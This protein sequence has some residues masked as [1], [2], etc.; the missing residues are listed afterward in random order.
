MPGNPGTK[1]DTATAPRGGTMVRPGADLAS[2]PDTAEM[3]QRYARIL[4]GPR[5]IAVDGLIVLTGLFTAISPWV[6]HFQDTNP[7]LTAVNLIVGLALTGLGLG[8]ALRPERMF[9]LGWVA[10]AIG[11]WLIISP[12]VA[13]VGNSAPSAQIWTNVCTGA[14]AFVLGLIALGLSGRR[15]KNGAS[16][17]ASGRRMRARARARAR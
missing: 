15:G 6:V 3:D 14:V 4:Q 1:P 8:M 2:H 5:A 12:W 7:S 9:K 16:G 10:S 13:S 17:G 11:V